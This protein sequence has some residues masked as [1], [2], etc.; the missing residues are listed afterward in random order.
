METRFRDTKRRM[1]TALEM[2]NMRVSYQIRQDLVRSEAYSKTLE[3]RVI[4]LET[5]DARDD[6]SELRGRVNLLYRDR[7]IHHHLAVMVEREAW[8]AREAWGFSMDVSDDT[9]SCFGTTYYGS[10]NNQMAEF[11]GQ[12]GSR[13]GRTADAPEEAGSC[14]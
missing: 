12:Q 14:S 1:M 2:V 7:P 6:R 9:C 13:K 3:A 5:E 4:V 8:M 10:G 11:Q